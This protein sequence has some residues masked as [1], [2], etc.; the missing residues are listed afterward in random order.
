M[1]YEQDKK[2]HVVGC[3]FDGPKASFFLVRAVVTTA[4]SMTLLLVLLVN[5]G[6]RDNAD[7]QKT[8]QPPPCLNDGTLICELEIR[9]KNNWTNMINSTIFS[10]MDTSN[11]IEPDMINSSIMQLLI[12]PRQLMPQPLCLNNKNTNKL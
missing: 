6:S 11:L 8:K 12:I 4:T 7:I 9:R 2:I 3:L 5:F 10:W 1:H